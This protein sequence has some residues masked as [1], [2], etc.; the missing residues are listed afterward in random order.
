MVLFTW[1]LADRGMP[2]C[3]FCITLVSLLDVFL[4]LATKDSPALGS[5]ST[6]PSS[7]LVSASAS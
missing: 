6:C 7:T 4:D 5:P 3:C 2:T 1:T